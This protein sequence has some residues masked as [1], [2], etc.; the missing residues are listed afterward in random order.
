VVRVRTVAVPV[1]AVGL[2]V[3]SA[4]AWASLTTYTPMKAE[5][6]ARVMAG[7]HRRAH[8]YLNQ[9]DIPVLVRLPGRDIVV[10]T[11]ADRALNSLYF[12]PDPAVPL[13]SFR[14]PGRSRTVARLAAAC[15][16]EITL[17]GASDDDL[18]PVLRRL[19]CAVIA[20]RRNGEGTAEV[21]DD[22]VTIRLG[23]ASTG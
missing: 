20:R 10:H 3:V 5:T 16:S 8:T 17:V 7:P 15:G 4:G 18:R 2:L 11:S 21:W 22:V 14:A 13:L 12:R 6:A 23:P 1:A 9:T 19:P